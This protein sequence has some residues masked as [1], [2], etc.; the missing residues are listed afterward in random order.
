ME[1]GGGGCKSTAG[2]GCWESEWIRER[3][4]ETEVLREG[5]ERQIEAWGETEYKEFPPSWNTLSALGQK[6]A[7]MFP[8]LFSLYA[9][10]VYLT[11]SHC[12]L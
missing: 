4:R 11:V 6:N 10:S 9:F 8:L 12:M 7:K 3:G 2:E 1:F 5:A